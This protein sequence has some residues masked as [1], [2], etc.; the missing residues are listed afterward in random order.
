MRRAPPGMRR[1]S[2]MRV[3][4]GWSWLALAA[5]CLV[6]TPLAV[7]AAEA[8]FGGGWY[9]G[10]DNARALGAAGYPQV[11][12]GVGATNVTATAASLTGM[13][14]A[15]GSVPA[16][17]QLFWAREDGGRDAAAWAAAPGAGSHDF[18]QVA[19]FAPLS[20][21]ITVEPDSTYYYRFFAINAAD[22]GGWAPATASFQTPAPP[23]VSTGPGA[24]VGF[25]TAGLHV[26]LTAGGAAQVWLDWGPADTGVAPTGYTTVDMGLRT[27]AGT[28]AAPNPCR[29]RI[30]GLAGSSTYAYRVRAANAY[31]TDASDWVW[32]TTNPSDFI[33]TPD[34]AWCGGGTRDGYDWSAALLALEKMIR[35]TILKLR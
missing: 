1:L 34:Q 7:V 15:E 6:M 23:Q 5:A 27:V 9:D 25:A 17:V 2:P 30:E 19:P 20:Y 10:Y 3:A 18:G 32:F 21:A 13:L 35:G 8:W 4:R 11:H 16:A 28:P 14:V 24:G 12:N 31:G 29:E 33:T 22:E 26:E